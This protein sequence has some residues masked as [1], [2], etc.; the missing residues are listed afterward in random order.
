MLVCECWKVPQLELFRGNSLAHAYDILSVKFLYPN[1]LQ[2]FLKSTKYSSPTC[3]WCGWEE[4]EEEV[5]V[6]VHTLKL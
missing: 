6:V 4:E 5:V 2:G 3:L 1:S